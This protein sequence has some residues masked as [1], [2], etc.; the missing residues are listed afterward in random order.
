MVNKRKEI[1]EKLKKVKVCALDMDGTI[2]LGKK[3]FP[4]T[5]AFLEGL[6]KAGKKFI[7]L[8]NNSSKNANDYYEKLTGIGLRVDKSQIY[9]SG[10]ATIEYLNEIK[11]G[12]RV[13]LMG[14]KNLSED[15]ER[16]GFSLVEDNPDFVVLGFDLT[17]TYQKFDKGA[18]FIRNKVPFIATHPDLNCPIEDKDMIPDCG[19]LSAAFTAATGVK[20][21]VLGKPNQE[22]LDG[23]LKRMNVTK[24]ELCLMGDRLM[25]DIKMGRDFGILSILVLTGEA[26]MEDL[27]KSDVVPDL[28]LEKNIDLLT[29]IE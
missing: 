10:D 9:T 13:Y 3:L 29:Y 19:A 25:T 21:K 22:M 12:A 14:T 16:A 7:F 4:F 1:L 11:P 26:S 6:S 2:Y 18:R 23:L 24:E 8:T 20:P 17:F 27:K 5:K 15:F 28:I